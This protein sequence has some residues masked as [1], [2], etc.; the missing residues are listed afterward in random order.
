M[1]MKQMGQQAND[2]DRNFVPPIRHM[3]DRRLDFP[4]RVPLRTSYIVAS[5]PRCG[6]TFFCKELWQ[7]GVLGAPTEYINYR[8]R[9]TAKMIGYRM[10]ERLNAATPAEYFT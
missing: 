8:N 5:S 9:P 4:S 6:S 1:Q 3:A 7:T 10:V 2:G